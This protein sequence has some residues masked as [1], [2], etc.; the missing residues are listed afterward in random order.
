MYM[1]YIPVVM[2]AAEVKVGT[3]RFLFRF[4]SR[5]ITNNVAGTL[6][7]YHIFL[8]GIWVPAV[9]VKGDLQVSTAERS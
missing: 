5:F 7:I 4:H 6:T 1:A 3:F 9:D 8:L 2:V